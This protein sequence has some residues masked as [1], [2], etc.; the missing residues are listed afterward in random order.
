MIAVVV[1][2]MSLRRNTGNG[3]AHIMTTPMGDGF[4]VNAAESVKCSDAM[5]KSGPVPKHLLEFN[6]APSPAATRETIL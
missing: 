3:I 5:E 6:S 1:T 4:A 2:T